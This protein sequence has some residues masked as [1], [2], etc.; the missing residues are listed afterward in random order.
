[1]INRIKWVVQSAP[2]TTMGRTVVTNIQIKARKIVFPIA[3]FR[4]ARKKG[5]GILGAEYRKVATAA[6]SSQG[7]YDSKG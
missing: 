7:Q 2:A 5:W 4:N 3:T 6:I 1:M